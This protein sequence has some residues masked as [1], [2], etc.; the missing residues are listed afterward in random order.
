MLNIE[1]WW[2]VTAPMDLRCVMDRLLGH[3]RLELKHALGESGAFAFVNRARTRVKLLCCD[4]HGVLLATWRLYVG[5]FKW[6][7]AGEATWRLDAE[8]FAWLCVGVNWQRL[9][10]GPMALPNA[11]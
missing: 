9:S 6:P 7:R 10:M 5:G 1:R 2:L 3:V 11:V 4:R 8:Q